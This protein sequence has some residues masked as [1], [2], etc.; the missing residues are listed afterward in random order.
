M[1]EGTLFDYKGVTV[2]KECGQDSSFFEEHSSW[3]LMDW[4]MRRA[5]PPPYLCVS[6]GSKKIS[7]EFKAKVFKMRKIPPEDWTRKVK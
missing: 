5:N 6:C 1:K 3:S 4:R 7:R 2:C